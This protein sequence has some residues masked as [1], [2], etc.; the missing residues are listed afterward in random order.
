MAE[1]SSNIEGSEK[2]LAATQGWEGAGQNCHNLNYHFKNGTPDITGND[3]RI[4]VLNAINTW[5]KYVSINFYEISTAGQPNCIDISWEPISHGDGNN[6]GP[7]TLAHAYYNNNGDIHFNETY[8]WCLQSATGGTDLYSVALHELGHSLG[9]NHSSLS[10]AVMYASYNGV[11]VTDLSQDDIDGIRSIYKYRSAGT[12][13]WDKTFVGN[14]TKE[15]SNKQIVMVNTDYVQGAIRVDD[16]I[17]GANL[18]WYYHCNFQGWMDNTDKM[19]LADANGDGKKD[20]I[21]VNTDY[22]QGAIRVINLSNG[23]D[24]LDKL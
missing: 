10:T 4:A 9:L 16:L 7:S 15:G 5:Q 20:L 2:Y 24:K 19:F 11:P 21:L 3:E 22:A 6:F 1:F 17:S 13:T 8:T 18:H 12:N 23:L 14:V